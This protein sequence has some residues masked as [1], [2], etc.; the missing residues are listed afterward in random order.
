MNSKQNWQT[1][2]GSM[3]MPLRIGVLAIQGDVIEHIHVLECLGAT[4]VLV[5][6]PED[7]DTI[8]AIIMP[9]GESTTM[10]LLLQRWGMFDVLKQRISD[11][12]PAWGTCAGAIMLAKEVRG[13]NPPQTLAAMDIAADRNA[14]GTH[15]DSF[16]TEIKLNLPATSLTNAT[17]ITIAAVFIRAPKLTPLDRANVHVLATHHNEPVLLQQGRLLAS[18]FHPELT[19]ATRIHQYFIEQ[20][21]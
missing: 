9:G 16:T 10:S 18:A 14:Y 20:C 13:K 19:T 2:A 17:H 15:R 21:L 5:R 1:V 7:C 12:M 8:D 3:V 11:G 4:P 6:R